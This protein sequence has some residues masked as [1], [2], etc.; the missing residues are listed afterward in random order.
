MTRGESFDSLAFLGICIASLLSVGSRMRTIFSKITPN[1]ESLGRRRAQ[2]NYL[3]AGR[4][5]QE[6]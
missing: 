4:R 2:S 1:S 6:N 3:D 5:K